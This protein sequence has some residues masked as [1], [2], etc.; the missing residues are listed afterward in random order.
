MSEVSGEQLF[1]AVGEEALA[2]LLTLAT[3]KLHVTC[4]AMSK[5]EVI[6]LCD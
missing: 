5:Y 6:C 2:G 4:W 1:T 3:P